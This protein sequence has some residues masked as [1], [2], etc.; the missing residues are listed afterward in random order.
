MSEEAATLIFRIQSSTL[1]ME[2][3]GSCEKLVRFYQNIRHHTTESDSPS[4]SI[5]GTEFDAY[6]SN[7]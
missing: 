1:K 5:R 4:A 6:M 2:V 3:A 7:Y